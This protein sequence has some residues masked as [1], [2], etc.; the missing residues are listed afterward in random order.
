MSIQRLVRFV[1]KDDGQTYYGAAD[2]AFQFAKPLQAGSPFSPETQISDNQHGIQKLLCPIDIDHARS[3]VCIG[4]NYTDHAEEANMAIPKLPVV[5]AW[6]LEPHLGGGQW[7]Y[8]K[9][10]DS[11]APIGPAIVSK[12]I[13]GSAVGLGI[14][15]TINDNQVQKGNTNNMIF[16][17]AEIV[18]FLSQGMTLLPGT[19]IFTGTPAGVGFGRTPQ[20]SMKEGD[21]IKIEID[22]IGAIS[23]RVVYE[24]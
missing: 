6:Q 12:D 19:L 5:L 2:K 9:C 8:S 16:S 24:Q 14:R 7:C 11:S 3:V 20:I 1:S 23:N 4:L 17:V 22:G 15:G 18:S 21:V 13:L 10:F